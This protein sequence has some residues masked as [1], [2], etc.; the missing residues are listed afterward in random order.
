MIGASA[1]SSDQDENR[2][3][4]TNYTKNTKKYIKNIYIRKK[5]FLYKGKKKR[6]EKKAGSKKLIRV[7]IGA[8]AASSDQDEEIK[9]INNK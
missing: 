3:P 6:R 2:K 1:A 5:Q 9:I 4:N 7:M 8:S